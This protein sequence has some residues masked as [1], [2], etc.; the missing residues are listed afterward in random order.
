MPSR[1]AR[2]VLLAL[3]LVGTLGGAVTAVAVLPQEASVR[4]APPAPDPALL[5][6]R[7]A[8]GGPPVRTDVDG[9]GDPDVLEVWSAGRRTR[10]F[11]EDDDLRA[12]E[13]R[14]DE[15]DD[16]VQVDRDGD[17]GYDG[18]DDLAVDWADADDDG[19]PDLQTVVVHPPGTR[20][21]GTPGGALW[22]VFEDV[23][24]DSV[25]AFVDWQTFEPDGWR[26]P[27]GGAAYAPDYN[28]DSLFLLEHVSPQDVEDPRLTW[29]NPFVF[30]DHDGDGLT[31]QTVRLVDTREQTPAGTSRW[32][33]RTDEA[34][35]S[36]D[37]DG[38]SRKGNEFDL[39]LSLK[40]DAR[41][42]GTPVDYRSSAHPHPELRA[43]DWVLPHLR[44]QSWRLLEELV[45]ASHAEAEQLALRSEGYRSAF[46]TTDA[47]DDDHRWERVELYWPGDPYSTDR[48]TPGTETGGGLAGHPQSDSLGDRG[49]WDLDFSGGGL[50]YVGAW[51]GEL[52][53]H[54]AE[55]GAWTVD[56]DARFWGG[57]MRGGPPGG[58]S[59][60]QATAVEAVVQ[61]ADTDGNG[62]VD[63]VTFDDDGD[64]VVDRELSLLGADEAALVDPAEVGW[65]G[66]AALHRSSAERRMAEATA[67]HAAVRARGWSTPELDAVAA[68]DD[69]R[70]SAPA[71]LRDGALRLLDGRLTGPAR[72]EL[73][74]AWARGDVDA[75]LALVRRA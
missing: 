10:W 48:W 39:D 11:D 61:Y 23:D 29:E 57:A 49:E 42:T 26:R 56:E 28:G 70:D 33:G 44:V 72:Q 21:D 2:L 54:G 41:G 73:R 38:D 27:T 64:R 5:R 12:E 37:L 32:D 17:G 43:P 15:Q 58:S 6:S 63:R 31:E 51:D 75:V 59:P 45:H 66:L 22:W 1:S 7:L 3:L 14:G 30:S 60:A 13:V 40:L 62:F 46:L 24:D 20:L 25:G 65:A 34:F 8:P 50:L 69:G 74:Q 67:L 47:D 55:R 18:P 53:L 16:F 4:A 36:W 68:A 9:D 71:R 35:V 19:D 52:H